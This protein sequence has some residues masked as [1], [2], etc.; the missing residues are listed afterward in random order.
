MFYLALTEHFSVERDVLKVLLRGPDVS[1]SVRPSVTDKT[2]YTRAAGP[3]TKPALL[4]STGP[5]NKLRSM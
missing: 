4:R 2:P 5:C 3:E 1:P